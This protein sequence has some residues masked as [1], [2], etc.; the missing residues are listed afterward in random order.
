[1]WKTTN[2]DAA[3]DVGGKECWDDTDGNANCPVTIGIRMD[4]LQNIKIEHLRSLGIILQ[5]MLKRK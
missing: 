4:A 1:M 5:V 2:S 3:K